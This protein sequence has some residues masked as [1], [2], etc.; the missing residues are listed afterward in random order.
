M[1][2]LYMHPVR[3]VLMLTTV[4]KSTIISRYTDIDSEHN[5]IHSVRIKRIL[6]NHYY[7]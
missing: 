3:A 1:I 5:R 4:G 7:N 2:Y 6:I